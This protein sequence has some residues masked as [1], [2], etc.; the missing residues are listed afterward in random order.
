VPLSKAGD[1]LAAVHRELYGPAARWRGFRSPALVRFL[2][3]E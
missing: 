1:C 2:R 3:G